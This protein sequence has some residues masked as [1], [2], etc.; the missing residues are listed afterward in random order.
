MKLEELNKKLKEV[1]EKIESE[2]IEFNFLKSKI[3]NIETILVGLKKERD[4]LKQL[5]KEKSMI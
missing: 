4:E 1:N 5:I 3:T 2:L